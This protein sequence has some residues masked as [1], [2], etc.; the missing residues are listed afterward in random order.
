MKET[1]QIKHYSFKT[2]NAELHIFC[3]IMCVSVH[4]LNTF[5]FSLGLGWWDDGN[6]FLQVP[7]FVAGNFYRFKN[8][9]YLLE[10]FKMRFF[11]TECCLYMLTLESQCIPVMGWVVLM[12]RTV[13]FILSF[14]FTFSLKKKKFL[15][16]F[17]WRCYLYENNIPLDFLTL[18]MARSSNPGL[19]FNI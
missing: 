18:T 13:L 8:D 5:L 16:N 2:I 12:L 15:F 10:V 19:W 4:V 3:K 1:F 6:F 14:S 9:G 17:C 11:L 7:G